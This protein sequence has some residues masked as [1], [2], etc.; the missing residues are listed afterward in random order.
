MFSLCGFKVF[1][2]RFV[3]IPVAPFITGIIIHL[4]CTFIISLYLNSSVLVY[5]LLPVP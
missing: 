2:K 5:V 4:N 3:N 1:F